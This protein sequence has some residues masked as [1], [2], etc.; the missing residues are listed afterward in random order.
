MWVGLG[1]L[2]SFPWWSHTWV[3]QDVVLARDTMVLCGEKVI[4]WGFTRELG[5][6]LMETSVFLQVMHA[7]SAVS[8]GYDHEL[9]ALDLVAQI[10]RRRTLKSNGENWSL[11]LLMGTASKKCYDSRDRL[12]GVIGLASEHVQQLVQIRYDLTSA[13]VYLSHTKWHAESA[14]GPLVLLLACSK[15]PMV[16]LPS[17]CPNFNA[18][19]RTLL[20]G[21]LA[22]TTKYYAGSESGSKDKT[23]YISCIPGRDSIKAQ[24]YLVD[25][26]SYKVPSCWKSNP[27]ADLYSQARTHQGLA[28]EASCLK[29]SQRVYNQPST[30]PEGHWR[31]LIANKLISH[32]CVTDQRHEYTLLLR[33]LCHVAAHDAPPDGQ[34]AWERLGCS[35]VEAANVQC[36]GTSVCQATQARSFVATEQGRVGLVPEEARAVDWICVVRSV[37]TPLVLRPRVYDKGVY[38]LVGESYV[39]GLMAGE[40]LHLYGEGDLK[41][42]VID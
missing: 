13:E 29:L 9:L 35:V 20:L 3:L 32:A 1:E 14:A 17:W 36:F 22:S 39:H 41:E 38:E 11:S 6:R 21:I 18:D 15:E 7:R 33:Y 40:A 27:F 42:V 2:F 37:S 10:R 26:I 5:A 34:R 8:L 25:K 19:S 24:G 16:G 12:F 23:C 28:W 31:T 30:I 4:P